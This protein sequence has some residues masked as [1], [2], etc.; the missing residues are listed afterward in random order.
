MIRVVSRSV[1]C[2]VIFLTVFSASL[3]TEWGDLS[4]RFVYEG[5]PPERAKLNVNKDV[6]I[7]GKLDLRD[8]SLIVAPDGGI[9][10]VLVYVRTKKVP[11]HPDYAKTADA[12][13]TIA[14]KGGRFDPH[15]LPIRLSQTLVITNGDRCGHNS[16]LQP[17]ADAGI[18]PLITEGGQ[19]EHRF[20][21]PQNIPVP[22]SCNIHPWMKGYIL[23]RRNPYVAVSGPDGT[24]KLKNVPAGMELEFQVWQERAGYVTK[25]IVAG[26][27]VAWKRGRFKM[28]LKPGENDL[29]T[30]KLPAE[31]FNK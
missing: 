21:R 20:N 7:F 11:V 22:I 29:G 17:I 1:G 12:K 6:D 3:A 30:I 24:F 26:K 9:A 18:N 15:I 23:P 13:V 19:V 16:N 14:N 10:N 31:I 25:A 27:P 2:A 28:T 8:E 5:K 4:G